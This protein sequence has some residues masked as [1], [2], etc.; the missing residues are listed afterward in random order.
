MELAVFLT[1]V[2]DILKPKYIVDFGSGFSSFV[3]RFYMKKAI[4][5]PVVWSVDDSPEWLNKTNL[6]LTR[7]GLH[8]N[9][10]MGWDSFIKQNK[11][12]F[13]LILNDFSVLEFRKQ[14]FQEII[15]MA[16][17]NGVIILDDMHKTE[18]SEYVRQSLRRYSFKHYSLKSFTKDKFGRYSTI[19]FRR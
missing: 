8:D 4:D 13:D 15:S 2:C 1:V 7:H 10:L 16:A 19:L 11:V 9:N 6:F 3:L 14:R 18:F 5:K 12:K 17:D